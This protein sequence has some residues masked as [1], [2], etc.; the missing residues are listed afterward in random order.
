M[1]TVRWRSEQDRPAPLAQGSRTGTATQFNPS[2]F[3]AVNGVVVVVADAFQP[4]LEHCGAL[5]GGGRV[6]A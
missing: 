2:E 1:P 6:T 3:L 4:R 5:A